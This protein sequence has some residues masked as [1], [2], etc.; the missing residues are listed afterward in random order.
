MKKVATRTV[1]RITTR[2]FAD[3]AF[4]GEGARLYGGRWNRVGTSV[5]Y[6]AENRSLAMLELMVQDAPM[7]AHYVVIPAHIPDS[8][9]IET[10]NKSRLS[11][12]W[13]A[14]ASRGTFQSIGDEWIRSS[15]TCVLAVPSAVMPT[16]LNFLINSSH[17]DFYQITI[18]KPEI[19]ETDMRLL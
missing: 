10:L 11:M 6:T 8:V 9:S 15:R 16:E 7:K 18:G 1:W 14:H 4:S 12:D 5:I 3:T 19:L 17:P 2:R 13:R